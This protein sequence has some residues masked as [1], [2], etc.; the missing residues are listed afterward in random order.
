MNK[1]DWARMPDKGQVAALEEFF[2][3]VDE[4]DRNAGSL[5]TSTV[6][7]RLLDVVEDLFAAFGD[8]NGTPGTLN[9]RAA[10]HRRCSVLGC[11]L[12]ARPRSL[13]CGVNH[14]RDVSVEKERAIDEMATRL[15]ELNE[16]AD[17]L[18]AERIV[19]RTVEL[20]DDFVEEI[21]GERNDRPATGE[22]ATA[23]EVVEREAADRR[24][25][26]AQAEVAAEQEGGVREVPFTE[27]G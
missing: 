16:H 12:P 5:G 1:I 11:D 13:T 3:R 24:R 7:S 10:L 14:G 18:S 20:V 4:L 9:I 26:A 17:E 25:E 22:I 15:D 21:Y 2:V 23:A 19:A 6:E 27:E 8:S